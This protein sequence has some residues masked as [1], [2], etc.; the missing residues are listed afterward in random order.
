[1]RFIGC[2]TQG[3]PHAGICGPSF[4]EHFAML[5]DPRQAGKVLYPLSEILLLLLCET[6][7]GADDF[8]EIALWGNEHLDFLRPFLPYQG[9]IP[10][11]RQKSAPISAQS[12]S[13][14]TAS[15]ASFVDTGDRDPAAL[16]ARCGLSQ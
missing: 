6:L 1:M 9:G 14:A 11:E 15:P 7:A 13:T 12:G 16:G 4:L 2:L 5:D 3:G 10:I 8:V